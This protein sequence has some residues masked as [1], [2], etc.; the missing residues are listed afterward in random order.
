MSSTKMPLFRAK[1][2]T[3]FSGN[4]SIYLDFTSDYL[5]FNLKNRFSDSN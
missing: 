5:A 3:A 2:V 1:T 4:V